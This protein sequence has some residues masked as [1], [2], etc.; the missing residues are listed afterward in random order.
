MDDLNTVQVFLQTK[1]ENGKIEF[2]PLT[3]L[4]E[5]RV[6]INMCFGFFFPVFVL[7]SHTKQMYLLAFV[8]EM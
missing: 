3:E 8:K 1:D 2:I 6:F 7:P 5:Y 4:N